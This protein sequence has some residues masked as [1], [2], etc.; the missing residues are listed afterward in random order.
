[1]TEKQYTIEDCER[2]AR[3]L[4]SHIENEKG[5]MLEYEHIRN[6]LRVEHGLTDTN[7]EWYLHKRLQ[8][9]LLDIKRLD[10]NYPHK[11]YASPSMGK[12]AYGHTLLSEKDLDEIYTLLC[13]HYNLTDSELSEIKSNKYYYTKDT[14]NHYDSEKNH[15]VNGITQEEHKQAVNIQKQLSEEGILDKLSLRKS[16]TLNQLLRKLSKDLKILQR[17]VKLEEDNKG[18][19][20]KVESLEATDVVHDSKIKRL[21]ELTGLEG[22]TDKDQV[23]L[24]D[25]AGISKKVIADTLGVSYRTV[26]RWLG[27]SK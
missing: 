12:T 3:E 5:R 9:T 25:K 18:L 7:K 2:E 23:F 22:L 16:S 26:R 20:H 8:Q 27:T 4:T 19:H 1:M 17:I 14:V 6:K 13:E 15:P 11:L 21:E 24:L 10:P